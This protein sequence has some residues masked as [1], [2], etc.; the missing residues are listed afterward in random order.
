MRFWSLAK[1]A[2]VKPSPPTRRAAGVERV[3]SNREA[4]VCRRRLDVRLGAS[5]RAGDSGIRLGFG[6]MDKLELALILC[7][8]KGSVEA[9]AGFA[10]EVQRR[11]V[12]R[13]HLVR[14][15]GAPALR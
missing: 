4:F 3:S 8:G 6:A 9:L 5:G 1:A 14:D 13:H 11:A 12:R 10:V 2:P 7:Q 15:V